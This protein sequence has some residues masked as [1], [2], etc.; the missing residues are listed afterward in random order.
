MHG[1]DS[2]LNHHVILGSRVEDREDSV[3]TCGDR[4]IGF[5]LKRIGRTSIPSSRALAGL[6]IQPGIHPTS[7]LTTSTNHH[8]DDQAAKNHPLHR[9]AKKFHVRTQSTQT[10]QNKVPELQGMHYTALV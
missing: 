10:A 7:A 6:F 1:M 3:K 5:A 2:T 8:G 9:D 4:Q